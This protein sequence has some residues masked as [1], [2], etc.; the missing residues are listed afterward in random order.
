MNAQ[1]T[2]AIEL[3]KNA[4]K[5]ESRSFCPQCEFLKS[6]C[7]CDTIRP[8]ENHV[9]VVIL[10]HKSET[11]HALNTVRILV[12]SLTNISLLIGEDFTHNDDLNAILC[13]PKNRC[14][15]IFPGDN[16]VIMN[17]ESKSQWE[18]ITHLIMID[19]TWRKAKKIFLLSKNLHTIPS[20]K[21]IPSNTSEYRIRK[22]PNVDGLSTLEATVLSLKS[23]EPELD[24]SSLQKSFKKMID[25]QIEQMGED[26]YKK[27]YTDKRLEQH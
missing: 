12:K 17:T 25:F 19:G 11:K 20:F 10:Q 14:G 9:K 4:Y 8:I 24:T 3:I 26:V 23:I 22:S 15:L 5:S 18:K 21:I 6:R 13:D 1:A 7:L 27:N 2:N 16:A